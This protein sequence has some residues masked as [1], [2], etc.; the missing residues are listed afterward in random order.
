MT[1]PRVLVVDDDENVRHLLRLRLQHAGFE[2]GE[3]ADGMVALD[4]V[5]GGGWDLV[6]LDLVMP[7]MTGFEFLK[8]VGEESHPPVVV[9][10][11]VEDFD[12]QERAMAMGA[13]DFVY[14]RHAFS[15]KFVGTI[16]KLLDH[17]A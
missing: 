6:V 15:R 3:A 14:K 5:R 2:V 13:D 7:N 9:I 4:A 8:R 12:C 10:T 1:T 16:R 17:A 11:Q